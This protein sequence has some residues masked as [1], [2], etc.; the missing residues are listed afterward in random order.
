M[1]NLIQETKKVLT[2]TSACCR[3]LGKVYTSFSVILI[4]NE[5]QNTVAE[6][7]QRVVS[8]TLI[9]VDKISQNKDIK[10]EF[11]N[12][13]QA[14]NELEELNKEDDELSESFKDSKNNE[15]LQ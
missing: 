9:A 4:N 12:I 5:F 14:F 7:I 6:T 3:M 8:E 13:S 1:K 15:D 10:N 2:Q 11:D